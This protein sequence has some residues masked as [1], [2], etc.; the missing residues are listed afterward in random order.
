MDKVSS[1]FGQWFWAVHNGQRV[2]EITLS[3]SFRIFFVVTEQ[4]PIN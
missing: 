1:I 3:L 2:I 4:H